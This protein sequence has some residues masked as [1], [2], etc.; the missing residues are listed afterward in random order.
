M[1][2]HLLIAHVPASLAVPLQTVNCIESPQTIIRLF[3]LICAKYSIYSGLMQRIVFQKYSCYSKALM[4]YYYYNVTY[5]MNSVAA[6]FS[7]R[8]GT[9]F[10]AS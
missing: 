6:L 7:D 1:I 4:F 8:S 10:I 5:V 9:H 2:I 3:A